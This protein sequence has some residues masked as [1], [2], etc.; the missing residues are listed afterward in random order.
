MGH[1]KLDTNQAIL[2]QYNQNKTRYGGMEQTLLNLWNDE[3]DKNKV[4]YGKELG[5]YSNLADTGG[6]N[7]D[8]S[9][10]IEDII[11]QYMG[12]AKTGGVDATGMARMRGNGVF[13]EFAKTGGYSEGDISNI[14][15]RSNAVIPSFFGAMKDNL[16]RMNTVQGGYS[17]GYTYQA[18]KMGR[19]AGRSAAEQALNTETT[20]KDKVNTGRE[21][22]ATSL[23]GAEDNL[24]R[25]LSGNRL[26]A[27][28]GAGSTRTGYVNSRNAGMEA[29]LGGLDRLRTTPGSDVAYLGELLKTMG[30]SDAQVQNLIN[31]QIS[32]KGFNPMSL[33]GLIKY[34]KYFLNTG[35]D[36]K[37][38]NQ[39]RPNYYD[40]DPYAPFNPAN[41]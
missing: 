8:D 31:S 5:G 40:P 32:N 22:G 14:R 36:T 25:L 27:L 6:W 16:D 38:G 12:I 33:L 3:R 13:D 26:A 37:T 35:K 21:W 28:G 15:Q 19:D 30:M 41:A 2:D 39:G 9:S 11:N 24:Q 34:A 18:S 7:A 4:T 23:S 29:G 17:P 20:I 1:K 10:N